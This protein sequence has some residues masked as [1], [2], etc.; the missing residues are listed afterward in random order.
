MGILAKFSRSCDR[1]LGSL[2]L[3]RFSP[4]LPAE[5]VFCNKPNLRFSP[6]RSLAREQAPTFGVRRT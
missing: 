6:K 4:S 3:R 1:A 5:Q 2:N